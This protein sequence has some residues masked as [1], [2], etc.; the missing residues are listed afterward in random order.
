MD[1]KL[2]SL[3]HGL[4]LEGFVQ[5]KGDFLEKGKKAQIGEIREW[6]GQK[7]QKQ[8]NGGWL[9]VKG[10]A[11]VKSEEK[12]ETEL[13]DNQ[14][15]AIDKFFDP[16][17]LIDTF[18]EEGDHNMTVESFKKWLETN[19]EQGREMGVKSLVEDLKISK[20]RAQKIYDENSNVQ[21]K[22]ILSNPRK[23]GLEE[24]TKS[25]ETKSF[26]E[27]WGLDFDNIRAEIGDNYTDAQIDTALEDLDDAGWKPSELVIPESARNSPGSAS[28][29]A[30]EIANKINSDLQHYTVNELDK[31]Q[32]TLD[33]AYGIVQ[34]LSFYDNEKS[35]AKKK[36]SK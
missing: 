25:E 18:E 7:F 22:E 9:P 16:Q 15:V 30:W 3:A 28:R 2:T 35:I 11:S 13:T 8:P 31:E 17:A 34:A 21:E 12:Q 10:N 20:E 27:D 24:G 29:K 6:R 14:K 4:N 19:K 36:G 23:Y 26:N 1:N 32:E 5:S 33:L